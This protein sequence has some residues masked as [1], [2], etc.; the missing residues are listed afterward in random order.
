[1]SRERYKKAKMK[2]KLAITMV[3]TSSFERLYVELE[4]K[5]RVYEVAQVWSG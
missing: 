5:G 2:A 1:M 4:E 3:K